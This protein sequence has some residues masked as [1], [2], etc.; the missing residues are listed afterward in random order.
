VSVRKADRR[1]VTYR[2]RQTGARP[3][4]HRDGFHTGTSTGDGRQG[5]GVRSER[6]GE[7][8][9]QVCRDIADRARGP[10]G[11]DRLPGGAGYH[12]RTQRNHVQFRHVCRRARKGISRYDH[13][14]TE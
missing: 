3:S 14:R 11:L 13:G 7:D 5:D 9:G 8:E 4:V 12:C 10:E 2:D 6:L 1:H